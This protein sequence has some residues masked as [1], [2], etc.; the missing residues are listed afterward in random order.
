MPPTAM[1]N[2]ASGNGGNVDRVVRS[3]VDL[4]C[5]RVGRHRD[6]VAAVCVRG[7]AAAA[8]GSAQGNR[9]AMAFHPLIS[10]G[11]KLVP[12]I[13]RVF[14]KDQNLYA[15]FEV[16]DPTLDPDGKTPAVAAE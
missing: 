7:V 15:Y 5:V 14:R 1:P 6:R 10:D 11:Q 12:S 3:G 2:G 9:R 4:E 13:T 8:V 16:Y